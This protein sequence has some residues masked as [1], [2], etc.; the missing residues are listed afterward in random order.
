MASTLRDVAARAGVSAIT[1]SRA[2]NNTGYVSPDTR[3]RIYAAVAELDYVPNAVASSLRSSKTQ[4]LA[5]LL[6]DITNP[7]WTTVARAVE[8]V[9]MA[10]GYGVLL[11]NTDE[12]RAKEASYLDLLLRRQIDGLVVAPTSESTQILRNLKKR[13]VPFVL[14]DRLVSGVEADNVRGDSR[15]G[16][17]DMTAHLL[18]TGYRRIGMLSG[19]LT[20]STAEER[21]AGYLDAHAGYGVAPDPGLIF[22]GSYSAIWSFQVTRELMSQAAYPD[23]IFAANNFIALGVLEALR[24]QGIRVPEDVAVVCFDDTPRYDSSPP[25]LTTVMQPAQQ[26]GQVAAGLLLDR[27]ADPER[28]IRE[29]VLP[30]EL[31]IRASCGCPPDRAAGRKEAPWEHPRS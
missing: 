5:L 12:D 1:V 6:T 25:F 8:D 30:T 2:L 4:L 17:Y 18:S 13:R 10:S 16:A 24:L 28:E 9:A 31:I 7:F 20:V 21:V 22:Y 15:Q 14:V 3:R 11:C 23:A 26:M 27:L 19:P 29:I